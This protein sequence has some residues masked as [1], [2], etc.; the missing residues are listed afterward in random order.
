[1]LES[2]YGLVQAPCQYYML[3]R[4]V[5]QKAGMKQ[6][7]TDECVFTCYVSNIIEQSSLTNEDLL[8]K[9]L[10]SLST[11]MVTLTCNMK[12]SSIGF[13]HT[14]DKITGAICCSYIDRL[15][16]KYGT[17]TVSWSS[18]ARKMLQIYIYKTYTDIYIYIYMYIY[19]YINI[20]RV[21]RPSL[22]QVRHGKFSCLHGADESR[23]R[24]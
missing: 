14:Y 24:P 3:C 10:R 12:E 15:L 18:T 22:G 5:C 1:M 19:I 6:L 17:S 8:V 21:H 4:E 11:K 16:V 9:N 23:L 13:Y 7:Q 20:L 2:I